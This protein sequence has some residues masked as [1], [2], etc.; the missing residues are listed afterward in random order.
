[1]DRQIMRLVHLKIM[2]LLGK[3]SCHEI[4]VMI[5]NAEDEI[6]DEKVKQ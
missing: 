5:D 4:K 2:Y 6:I 3:Y 1:M